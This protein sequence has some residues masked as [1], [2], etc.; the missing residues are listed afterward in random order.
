MKIR[1]DM[2]ELFFKQI[3]ISIDNMDK[4]GEKQMKRSFAKSTCYD[5]LINYIPEPIKKILG[6]VKDKIMS[7]FKTN[8]TEDCIKPTHVS[9]VYGGGK[10]PSKP[11]TKTIRRQHN[12][13]CKKSFQ[14]KKGKQ[15]I[16]DRIIIDAGNLFEQEVKCYSK[17]VKGR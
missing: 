1:E 16:K 14:T 7:L 4:F 5:W 9:N 6:D 15:A 11:K 13:G 17:P 3:I 2:R 8:T 12:C 10:K